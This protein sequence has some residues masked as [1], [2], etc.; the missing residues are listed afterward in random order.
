MGKETFAVVSGLSKKTQRLI[1][2]A[3]KV[4]D[5]GVKFY[6]FMLRGF[7]GLYIKGLNQPLR[8]ETDQHF[9][10][11][12]INWVFE[13]GRSPIT[14]LE[15]EEILQYL[16]RQNKFKYVL[17]IVDDGEEFIGSSLAVIGE[18]CNNNFE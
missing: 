8:Y 13:N 12:L 10:M 2:I 14:P 6:S 1:A 11:S 15:K 18:W 16:K 3:S 9:P 17:G 4:H 7:I 5:T